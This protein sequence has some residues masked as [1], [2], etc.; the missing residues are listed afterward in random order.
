M[1][2][3]FEFAKSRD[4]VAA[5]KVA[6]MLAGALPQIGGELKIVD[7][8]FTDL[9]NDVYSTGE[10]T[11]DMAFMATNFVAAFDPYVTFGGDGSMGGAV[12]TFGMKDDE[13]VA[14]ALAMRNTAPG[15]VTGYMQ[16]WMQ[17]I[18]RYNEVLPT[19]PIYSN[20]YA[21]AYTA[22]LQNYTVQD[23]S[24]W[25]EAIIYAYIGEQAE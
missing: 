3:S 1:P 8:D 23:G 5:D 11:Y 19:L 2:L 20:V 7:V 12:C 17:M 6:D 15:N 16:N 21:D 24:G 4:N 25:P 10:R 22:Q 14:D 13:L 18:K 9:L